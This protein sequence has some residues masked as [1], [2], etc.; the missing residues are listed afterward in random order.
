MCGQSPQ[1]VVN[2]SVENEEK[3][4]EAGRESSRGTMKATTSKASKI[5]KSHEAVTSTLH[6]RGMK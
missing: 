4:M 1:S 6:P 2:L 3:Y 5:S